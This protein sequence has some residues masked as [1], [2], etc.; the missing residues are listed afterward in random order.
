MDAMNNRASFDARSNYGQ[1]QRLE[2]LD[3]AQEF[4]EDEIEDRNSALSQNWRN[5][6]NDN[7]GGHVRDSERRRARR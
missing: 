2:S 6:P 3:E 5:P 7:Y 4:I 1:P